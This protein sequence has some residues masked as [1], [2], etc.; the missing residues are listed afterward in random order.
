MIGNFSLLAISSSLFRIDVGTGVDVQMSFTQA[1][2]AKI[3]EYDAT[4]GTG[5]ITYADDSSE[6]ITLGPKTYTCDYP[7]LLFAY[8]SGGSILASQSMRISSAQL[9]LN[10]V[11][12][13]DYIPVRVG[14]G[15]NAVGYLYDRAN[16][17]GGP[18]GNGLYGNSG[19]GAFVIGPD[20]NA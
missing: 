8:N 19:S 16:P 4:T 3:A 5:T 13:R 20:A 10:G 11:L 12:V 7:L 9:T 18:L 14:T 6:S 17:T 2:N 15:A 1:K